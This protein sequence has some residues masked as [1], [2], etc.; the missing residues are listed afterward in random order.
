MTPMHRRGRPQLG[1]KLLDT[2]EA[3]PLAKRRL[4]AILLTLSGE[5]TTPDATALLECNEANFY[6]LRSRS[7]REWLAGLEPRQA[8]RKPRVHDPKDDEI[9]RLRKELERVRHIAQTLDTRLELAV[10]GIRPRSK[11]RAT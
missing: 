5:W 1:T 9:A 6:A 2:I 4:R 3:S 8:G 7:L 11:K 10:A